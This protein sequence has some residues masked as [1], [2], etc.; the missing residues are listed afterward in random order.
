MDPLMLYAISLHKHANEMNE[1]IQ[2]AEVAVESNVQPPADAALEIPQMPE[3]TMRCMKNSINFVPKD[4]T[5]AFN[6]FDFA[7]L[8]G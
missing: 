2:V 6:P 7:I 3:I 4:F 8:T 5:Y 1:K